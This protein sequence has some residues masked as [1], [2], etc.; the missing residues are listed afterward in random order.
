MNRGGF[1]LSRDWSTAASERSA[2]TSPAELLAL[3]QQLTVCRERR[4]RWFRALCHAEALYRY[5]A[6][7]LWTTFLSLAMLMGLVVLIA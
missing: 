6:G 7:H 5:G 1:E 3:G 4:G 2:D